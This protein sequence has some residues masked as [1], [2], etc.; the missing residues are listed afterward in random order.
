MKNFRFVV[1]SLVFLG[2]MICYLDRAA[3]SYAITPLSHEFHLNNTQFG[4]LLSCFGVGYI[5]TNV[6]GG[7]IADRIGPKLVWGGA[8]ILWS[9]ATIMFGFAMGFMSLIVLRILLGL[10]EG[11]VFPSLSRTIS[12]WLP[13]KEKAQALSFGLLAIPISAVI[14]APISTYLIV[15]YGWRYLFYI[16]GTVGIIWSIIWLI[17]Y[18]NKPKQHKFILPEELQY[19]EN[20]RLETKLNSTGDKQAYFYQMFTNRTFLVTCYAYFCNGYMKFFIITWLPGYIIQTYNIKLEDLG[21]WLVIPWLLAAFSL[22][23]NGYLADKIWQKTHS[24]RK[25]R[26]IIILLSLI[27]TA[28]FLV[29]LLSV[30]TIGMAMIFISIATAL[31]YMADSCIYAVT[32]DLNSHRAG[33]NLAIMNSFFGLSGIIAPIV[34]GYLSSQSHNF[35]TAILIVVLL[36]LSAG[37]L[38]IFF[39]KPDRDI[40]QKKNE[41]DLYYNA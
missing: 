41:I 39:H 24:F 40:K 37:I 7:Y 33:I 12:D 8:A 13:F 9:I 6:V 2:A 15:T 11:P 1:V 35:K 19:I 26:S 30:T 17:I 38:V 21:I 32:S 4:L 18:T 20:G 29:P 27:T 36:N 10:A 28:L 5:V 3:L 16:L 22:V 31:T 23:T 14:G 25:S 34:T